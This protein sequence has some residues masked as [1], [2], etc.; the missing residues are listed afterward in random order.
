MIKF[1]PVIAIVVLFALPT[2]S[3][4]QQEQVAIAAATELQQNAS[5]VTLTQ[6]DSTKLSIKN[7]QPHKRAKRDWATW[8]PNPKLT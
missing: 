7:Q 6:G 3:W 8:K 5:Y 1:Y 2:R 4:A